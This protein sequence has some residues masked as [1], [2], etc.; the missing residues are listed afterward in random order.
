MHANA[1]VA[2]SRLWHAARCVCLLLGGWSVLFCCCCLPSTHLLVAEGAAVPG[3]TGGIREKLRQRVFGQ[4]RAVDAVAAAVTGWIDRQAGA[5]QKDDEEEEEAEEE[6]DDEEEEEE[7]EEEQGHRAGWHTRD[8]PVLLLYGPKHTGKHLVV[9]TVLQH[10]QQCSGMKHA[11]SSGTCG[12]SDTP[13]SVFK[14][15]CV[16]T[17]ASW[18]ARKRELESFMEQHARFQAAETRNAAHVRAGGIGASVVIWN[19]FECVLNSGNSVVLQDV[20]RTLAS[21]ADEALVRV[22][23]HC[24]D[25]RSGELLSS[26][27]QFCGKTVAPIV[28]M[29]VADMPIDRFLRV[30]T[31][32]L[33][34][35]NCQHL[36][37]VVAARA[38]RD[39]MEAEVGK[40]LAVPSSDANATNDAVHF[41]TSTSTCGT[42]CV[43]EPRALAS[44]L[45]VVPFRSLLYKDRR[46]IAEL[47]LRTLDSETAPG[48]HGFR[49]KVDTVASKTPL[50]GQAHALIAT[51]AEVSSGNRVTPAPDTPAERLLQDIDIHVSRFDASVGRTPTRVPCNDAA[52]AQFEQ[53]SCSVPTWW[54]KLSRW[55]VAA[56]SFVVTVIFFQLGHSPIRC[57]SAAFAVFCLVG[58]IEFFSDCNWRVLLHDARMLRVQFSR[59]NLV[60]DDC[61]CTSALEMFQPRAHSGDLDFG[62]LATEVGP[63]LSLQKDREFLR[64]AI[65]FELVH[66]RLHWSVRTFSGVFFRYW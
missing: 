52:C 5:E 30:A 33:Q 9:D 3:G 53:P 1:M 66:D 32:V 12:E 39:L 28:V 4:P 24:P 26:Q 31:T 43:R 20:A 48:A 58:G 14:I 42:Q 25:E 8:S 29:L 37:S 55:S 50:L 23:T 17:R 10:V 27:A 59:V 64:Q 38:L 35:H 51:C 56:L 34:R 36:D 7:E 45:Q 46:Q 65:R 18:T 15:G 19:E 44:F 47:C 57:I 2:G 60:F 11:G 40:S 63:C 16:D 54:K 21:I 22:P 13:A 62:S 6:N 41:T 61:L 49:S